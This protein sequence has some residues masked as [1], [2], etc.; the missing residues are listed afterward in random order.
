MPPPPPWR[1][2]HPEPRQEAH[3]RDRPREPR[4]RPRDEASCHVIPRPRTDGR[5]LPVL[6]IPCRKHGPLE[7]NPLEQHEHVAPER[8]APVGP[9]GCLAIALKLYPTE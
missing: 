8:A 6:Q 1:G 5:A 7:V 9:V 3:P 2:A 4:A